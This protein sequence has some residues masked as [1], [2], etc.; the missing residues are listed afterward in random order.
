MHAATLVRG[1]EQVKFWFRLKPAV[2]DDSRWDVR[3]NHATG[4][5]FSE[6]LP[7]HLSE[8]TAG[9]NHQTMDAGECREFTA[10]FQHLK[11]GLQELTLL[12]LGERGPGQAADNAVHRFD[13][14]RVTDLAHIRD[15]PFMQTH[16]GKLAP[17]LGS[18]NRVEFNSEKPARERDL[19]EYVGRKDARCR[20]VFE[21][22]LRSRQT[23]SSHDFAGERTGTR[24]DTSRGFG[25]GCELPQVVNDVGAGFPIGLSLQGIRLVEG[26]R[27]EFTKLL[28][29]LRDFPPSSTSGPRGRA[30][31]R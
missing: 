16:I 7:Q 24:R 4:L 9:R 30:A 3:P 27:Q 5:H 8:S 29:I 23:Q 15:V 25:I 26:K 21:Y 2:V 19:L 28:R 17:E 11:S 20:A 6:M 18:E 10:G 1:L 14:A 13:A 22:Y 12:L 31:C